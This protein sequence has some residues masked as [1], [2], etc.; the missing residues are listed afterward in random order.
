[1][2][3]TDNSHCSDWFYSPEIVENSQ[4]N[5]KDYAKALKNISQNTWKLMRRLQNL[6][7]QAAFYNHIKQVKAYHLLL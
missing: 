3:I 6:V 4:Q 1:M 2:D 5:W 7:I